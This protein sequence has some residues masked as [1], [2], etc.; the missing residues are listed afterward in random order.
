MNSA[1]IFYA[2]CTLVVF[3]FLKMASNNDPDNLD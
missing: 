3:A 1:L 2:V